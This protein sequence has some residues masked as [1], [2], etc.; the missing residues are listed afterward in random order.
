MTE[1]TPSRSVQA[2]LWVVF[3]IVAVET[4]LEIAFVI[5][6]EDYGPGGK[7]LLVLLFALKLVFA[8][9]V[10]RLS[11]GAVFGLV[12]FELGALP[13]AAGADYAVVLRLLLVGCVISTIA[14]LASC[15]H[16]FPSPEVR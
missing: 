5:G 3:A 14:L 12:L 16:A 10:R 13:V 8:H 4:G 7:G 9:F 15:L 1:A 2:R 11:A 6:R